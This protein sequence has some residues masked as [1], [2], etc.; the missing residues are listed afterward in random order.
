M[1]RR[2][3]RKFFVIVDCFFKDSVINRQSLGQFISFYFILYIQIIFSFFFGRVSVVCWHSF[4]FISQPYLA[5]GRCL[6][7][8]PEI[9]RDSLSRHQLSQPSICEATPHS[10]ICWMPALCN[11]QEILIRTRNLKL[12]RSPGIDSKESIL[13][14]WQP[15]SYLVPSPHRLFINS[16]TDC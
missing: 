2:N 15:C 6:D 4:A 14:V 7:S 16:S 12:L 5:S 1:D 3:V 9:C 10:G 8:N 13:P 11:S